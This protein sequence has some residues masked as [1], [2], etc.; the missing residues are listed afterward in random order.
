MEKSPQPIAKSIIYLATTLKRNSCDIGLN[1]IVRTANMNLNTKGC[2]LNV[3]L[4][5][6]FKERI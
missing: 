3:H 4:T 1:I 6:V 2:G 5:E